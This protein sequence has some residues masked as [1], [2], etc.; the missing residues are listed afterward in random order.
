MKGSQSNMGIR[1]ASRAR[2]MYVYSESITGT[3]PWPTPG[4]NPLRH[5]NNHG[6]TCVG[7]EG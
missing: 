3:G 4:A 6:D 2:G 5:K 7:S 1:F